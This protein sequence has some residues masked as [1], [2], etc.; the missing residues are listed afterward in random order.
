M[1]NSQGLVSGYA[2]EIKQLAAKYQMGADLESIKSKVDE[3][4]QR[5]KEHIEVWVNGEPEENWSA[6]SGKLRFE[7]ELAS[8]PKWKEIV[9]YAGNKILSDTSPVRKK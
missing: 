2:T 4:I 3:T 9:L 1:D 7:G 5:A 8:D 6:L